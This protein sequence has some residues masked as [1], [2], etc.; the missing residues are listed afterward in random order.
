MVKLAIR[1]KSGDSR[2]ETLTYQSQAVVGAAR[3]AERRGE[4]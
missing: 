1:E 4:H 2:H 3:R